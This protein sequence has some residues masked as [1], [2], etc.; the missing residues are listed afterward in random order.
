[1]NNI[2]RNK[3]K[4][5]KNYSTKNIFI[6]TVTLVVMPFIIFLG[7]NFSQINFFTFTYFLSAII[8]CIFFVFIAV[9]VIHIFKQSISSVLIFFI[10]YFNFLQFY[11]F[12]FRQII[13]NHFDLFNSGFY[14]IAIILLVS[15]VAAFMSRLLIFRNFVLII[16]FLNL[17]FS[18]TNLAPIVVKNIEEVLQSTNTNTKFSSTLIKPS[19]KYPNIFYIIPDGLASPEILRKYAKISFK[20]SVKSFENKGFSVSKHMYASYNTTQLSLAALFGMKYPVTENSPL[21]KDSLK[22][23]PSIRDR[24]SE[25]L[26]YLKKNNYEFIIIPPQWG[27]CPTGKEYKCIVPSGSSFFQDYAISEMFNY[28]LIKHISIHL[29]KGDISKKFE[30]DDSVKTALNYIKKKPQ[31]WKNKGVFTMIHMV[32]PH[33][34]YRTEDCVV[35]KI[36]SPSEEG[37]RSSVKCAF[38]RIHE[39]S[40]Y[41]IKNYP[42]ANIIVQGDHGVAPSREYLNEYFVDLPKSF[43]DHRM[44]IFTAVRGCNSDQASKMNQANIVE[45]IVECLINGV[46]VKDFSNKSF[47]AFDGNAREY[48]KVFLVN[49]NHN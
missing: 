15:L 39:L 33:P 38:N 43:I 45:Y 23:Y 20:E 9:I 17:I 31:Y 40:K 30:M 48:G 46:S 27:G 35:T 44:G 22:F 10:A 25:L 13:I 16:L 11:Y 1:M 7:N 14:A 47:Y 24:N 3:S 4:N 21:Y 19:I 42:D 2:L 49:K 6:L 18:L 26:K 36:L 28:S 37:Y 32:I 5:N 29:K 41:L 8:Y 34:P 12:N